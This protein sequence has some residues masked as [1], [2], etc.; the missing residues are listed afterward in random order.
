MSRRRARRGPPTCRD[1]HRP[2]MWL[3]WAHSG[4]WRTFDP[5]P[6][7]ANGGQHAI[8]YPVEGGTHAWRFRDLVEDLRVRRQCSEL[9][10]EGEAHDMPWHT[11]HTCPTD[12]EGQAP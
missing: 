8:A 3:R 11:P 2:V 1:Y 10:A 7:P 12:T 5:R 9:E 4:H 6:V